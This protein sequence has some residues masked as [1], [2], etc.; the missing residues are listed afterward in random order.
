MSNKKHYKQYGNRCG[1]D[2]RAP[3]FCQLAKRGKGGHPTVI[4]IVSSLLEKSYTDRSILASWQGKNPSGRRRRSEARESMVSL[5]QFLFAQW[6]QLE[7]RRCAAPSGFFLQ[8]PNVKHIS[9]KI[10][11][12]SPHWKRSKLSKGRIHAIFG[13]FERCGYI[14]SKQVNQHMPNGDWMPSPSIRTFTKKFFIELGG[15]KLWQSIRKGGQEKLEK[16]M[17]IVTMGGLTLKQ[18]LKA[19][20]I[21]TPARINEYK[22]FGINANPLFFSNKPKHHNAKQ[23]GLNPASIRET[24]EYKRV[25]TEKCIE[26][27]QTH[28]PDDPRRVHWKEEERKDNARRITDKIFNI[29]A[30]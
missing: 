29:R 24:I 26:L 7:T 6:F 22:R 28:P 5:T 16:I 2:K 4:G 21:A 13:E 25:F 15:D 11:E 30:A 20:E 17:P 1:H 14:R 18:F 27:F 12:K 23:R 10:T 9:N 19:D 3:R 8:V